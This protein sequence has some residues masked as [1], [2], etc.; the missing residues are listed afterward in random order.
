MAHLGIASSA[1]I[2]ALLLTGAASGTKGQTVPPLPDPPPIKAAPW[3]PPPNRLPKEFVEAVSLLQRNGLPDPRGGV[4]GEAAVARIGAWSGGL[5]PKRAFGWIMPERKEIVTLGGLREPI[6]KVICF[7]REDHR[8][9]QKAEDPLSWSANWGWDIAAAMLL[10]KGSIGQAQA[11]LKKSSV[12]DGTELVIGFAYSRVRQMLDHF[13][14]G[15]YAS[16]VRLG[17]ELRWSRPFLEAGMTSISSGR[18][19]AA[20]PKRHDLLQKKLDRLRMTLQPEALISKAMASLD[21]RGENPDPLGVKDRAARIRALIESLDRVE[22]AQTGSPGMIHYHSDPRELALIKEGEPALKALFHAARSDGRSISY[23]FTDRIG[24]GQGM[25][26]LSVRQIAETTIERI[27][28]VYWADSIPGKSK[29]EKLKS[30]WV[31]TTGMS[32]PERWF[33]LLADESGTLTKWEEAAQCLFDKEGV[34]RIGQGSTLGANWQS[35]PKAPL[36][37]EPLRGRS[38]PSLSDLLA[39]RAERSLERQNPSYPHFSPSL[40]FAVK[41]YAWEPKSSL[42][43]LQKTSRAAM[44]RRWGVDDPIGRFRLARAVVGRH[45]LGDKKALAEWSAFI[46]MSLPLSP[47]QEASSLAPLYEAKNAPEMNKLAEELF[48][49]RGSYWIP[50]PTPMQRV[51]ELLRMS[52]SRLIET[53]PVKHR[54]LEALSDKTVIG[55]FSLKPQPTHLGAP[56]T[57][58]ELR[59]GGDTT[60]ANPPKVA[61]AAE[62]ME[63]AKS[64]PLRM[65]DA[66]A[67]ELKSQKKIPPFE[68]SWPL[69]QR[70]R[71]LTKI[72]SYIRRISN[73]EPL[74]DWP[75]N[76][77]FDL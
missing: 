73:S 13:R 44:Q 65:A 71:A 76:G 49:P 64:Q 18:D 34:E 30:I 75:D 59:V 10:V 77:R 46:R 54:L 47:Y 55:K 43:A 17:Q 19:E 36:Q 3:T 40:G 4:F 39:V 74:L 5:P 48:G 53:A 72:K 70:D 68:L 67:S 27:L 57:L 63:L 16:V 45:H 21:E 35:D 37:A 2:A 62:A 8:L 14:Q 56:E 60:Y 26:S 20:D 69:E 58:F 31:K 15:D 28:G 6:E 11:A 22:A 9:A 33:A 25:R 66:L 38:N 61:S 24:G 7:R 29:L 23:S 32:K 50:N 41:L 52:R 1:A 51:H 12:S 42:T